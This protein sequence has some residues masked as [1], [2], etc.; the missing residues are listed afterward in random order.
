MIKMEYYKTRNDGVALYRTYSDSNKYIIQI[1][2]NRRYTEAIDV[3]PIRYT[4]KETEYEI[5]QEPKETINTKFSQ[6]FKVN[7]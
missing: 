6:L 3:Y 7:K 1:E 2:T 4:Y 5:G